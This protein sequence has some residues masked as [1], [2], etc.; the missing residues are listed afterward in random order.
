MAGQ[1]KRLFIPVTASDQGFL[2]KRYKLVPRTLIF[3]RRE[4]AFLL[5]LG[6][7]QKRLWANRYNGIGGH[8]ERGEDP[9]SAAERELQEEAGIQA[10]LWL[11]GVV[12]IDVTPD[13]GVGL[14]VFT[15][16][17]SSGELKASQEGTLN[18]VEPASLAGLPLV[19][20][21]PILLTK[22]LSMQPGEP[23]FSARYCYEGQRL[24]IHFS[25]MRS[26]TDP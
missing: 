20:D 9:L 2:D 6:S 5:L 13:A 15:G 4:G 19:E 7:P 25:E 12:T 17:Y 18:W 10:D 1:S 23:P 8:I 26:K 14:Y 16:E 11:C 21:L 22:I 24:V 3:V